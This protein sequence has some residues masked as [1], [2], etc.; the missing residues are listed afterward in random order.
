[1]TIVSH[2]MIEKVFEF[3]YKYYPELIPVHNGLF[4][5]SAEEEAEAY[6]KL[7]DLYLNSL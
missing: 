3:G 2:E 6:V 7:L 1:M 5:V 4:S